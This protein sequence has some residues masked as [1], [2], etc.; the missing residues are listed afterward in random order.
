MHKLESERISKIEKENERLM[1]MIGSGSREKVKE[2]KDMLSKSRRASP[3]K[4]LMIANMTTLLSPV[5]QN[6]SMMTTGKNVSTYS[7]NNKK[8]TNKRDWK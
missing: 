2:L 5:S 8:M 7:E 6:A 1:H 4:T 3:D